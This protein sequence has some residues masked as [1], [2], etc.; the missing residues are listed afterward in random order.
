MREIE[1]TDGRGR[2]RGAR[3]RARSQC[4]HHFVLETKRCRLQ[5]ASTKNHL[6]EGSGLHPNSLVRV[7]ITERPDGVGARRDSKRDTA[8]MIRFGNPYPGLRLHLLVNDGVDDDVTFCCP[9]LDRAN[10]P[11][12]VEADAQAAG[13][14][15]GQARSGTR[16]GSPF[17]SRTAM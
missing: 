17:G 5:T 11:Y 6:S 8:A 12:D 16:A 9:V 7:E 15:H 3:E 13:R 4:F 10:H 14:K 1:V 2:N